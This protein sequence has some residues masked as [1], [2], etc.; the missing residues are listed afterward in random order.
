MLFLLRHNFGEAYTLMRDSENLP[1][2]FGQES[3]LSFLPILS[4]RDMPKVFEAD[5]YDLNSLRQKISRRKFNGA[6]AN[7][8]HQIFHKGQKISSRILWS[9]PRGDYITN[10]G[11]FHFIVGE[12]GSVRFWANSKNTNMQL[13]GLEEND[14]PF[15]AKTWYLIS[16][17]AEDLSKDE[18]GEKYGWPLRAIT[19]TFLP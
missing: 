7:Y 14:K 4:S 15:E 3:D 19:K 5:G 8:S 18:E 10:G 12:L 11:E 6:K 13:R 16:Q 17:K 1:S 9:T 2:L